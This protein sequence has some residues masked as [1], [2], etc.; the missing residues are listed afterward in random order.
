M[1]RE[2]VRLEDNNFA[3]WGC[4]RCGWILAGKRFDGPSL[5]KG[6]KLSADMSA[7]SPLA[8]RRLGKGL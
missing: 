1:A 7:P 6:K 3:A 4:N 5:L 2:L 8:V